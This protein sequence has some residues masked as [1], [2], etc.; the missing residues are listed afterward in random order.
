MTGFAPSR[1]APYLT[2]LAEG[3]PRC[4]SERGI[5]VGMRFTMT[6]DNA[7]RAARSLELIEAEGVDKFYLS[8][9]NYASR[10]N[11]NRKDDVNP[12][13]RRA[14]PS[15]CCSTA[16]GSTPARPAQGVRHRR[17]RRRRGLFIAL[18]VQH[19]PHLEEHLRAKLAQ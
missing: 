1:A 7:P 9:L 12:E 2:A 11:I 18:G 15:T 13:N 5:K 8:H 19:F 17:Q 3:H 4:V 14:R 6:Q 16:A 10:G